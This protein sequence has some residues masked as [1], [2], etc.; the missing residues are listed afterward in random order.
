MDFSASLRVWIIVLPIGK[1]FKISFV[2]NQQVAPIVK[3]NNNYHLHKRTK[4][5]TIRF[6]SYTAT[7][8]VRKLCCCVV[9]LVVVCVPFVPPLKNAGQFFCGCDVAWYSD[10][11]KRFRNCF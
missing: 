1:N 6:T 5:R 8:I 4:G 11:N 10:W 3:N 2:Y 9:H 7:E